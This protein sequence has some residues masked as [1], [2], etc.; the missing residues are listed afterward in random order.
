MLNVFECCDVRTTF[1][2]QYNFG[3]GDMGDD[4]LWPAPLGHS[5]RLNPD[6]RLLLQQG[7]RS[8]VSQVP[9]ASGWRA[10]LS[11]D[12][13]FRNMQGEKAALS[14]SLNPPGPP[15]ISHTFSWQASVVSCSGLSPSIPQLYFCFSLCFATST[16]STVYLFTPA[17]HPF[18]RRLWQVA[19]WAVCLFERTLWPLARWDL[20]VIKAC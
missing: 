13:I 16:P 4:W 3:D 19:D 6:I 14:W 20:Q 18:C 12:C 11:T 17:T 5:L 10:G 1:L 7:R 2:L 9:T 15:L 8:E